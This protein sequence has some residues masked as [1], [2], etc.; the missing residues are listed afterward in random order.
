MRYRSLRMPAGLALLVF[1]LLSVFQ[2][3]AQ[4]PSTLTPNSFRSSRIC[5]DQQKADPRCDVE[6]ICR[7]SDGRFEQNE[8]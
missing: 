1:A 4:T 6:V 5:S 3:Q 7:R 8:R 2:A